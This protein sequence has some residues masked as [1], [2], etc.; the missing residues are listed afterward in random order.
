VVQRASQ[1]YER[2][3]QTVYAFIPLEEA[4]AVLYTFVGTL[5]IPEYAL[6]GETR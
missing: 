4:L 6:Q 3:R 5:A 1:D 2:L